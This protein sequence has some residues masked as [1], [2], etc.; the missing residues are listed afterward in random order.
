MINFIL[1]ILAIVCVGLGILL[2]LSLLTWICTSFVI[3]GK[4]LEII[5]LSIGYIILIL[6]AFLFLIETYEIG[7]SIKQDLKKFF[8]KFKK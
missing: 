6:G 7:E 5:F 1:G 8:N 4:I 2:L 3:I